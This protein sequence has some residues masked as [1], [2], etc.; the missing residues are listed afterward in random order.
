MGAY[1]TIVIIIVGVAFFF[2]PS[3]PAY[4]VAEKT[5]TA[6][7]PESFTRLQVPFIENHGQ[8]EN[9]EAAYFAKLVYGSIYIDKN[10]TVIHNYRV[11][12]KKA[13]VFKEIFTEK[14]IAIAALEPPA[15]EALLVLRQRGQLTGDNK[16]YYRISYGTIDKGIDLQLLAFTDTLEKIFT[17]SPGGNPGSIAVTLKGVEGAKVNDAGEL[18]IITKQGPVKFGPPHAYQFV[19]ETRKLVDI[20]YAIRNNNTYGFKLGG[21]DKAQPLFI[22]PIIPAFLLSAP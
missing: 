22:A 3:L 5:G 2:C 20:A 14:K 16:N 18:E 21:Y 15:E 6:D 11:R 12:D 4:G 17:I 9:K 8:I 13:I 10:G 19:G 7:Q 1:R